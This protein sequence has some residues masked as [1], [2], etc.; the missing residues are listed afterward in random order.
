MGMF[1]VKVTLKYLA[2]QG[3]AEDPHLSCHATFWRCFAKGWGTLRWQ[4]A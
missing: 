2:L 3:R 4:N 1:N